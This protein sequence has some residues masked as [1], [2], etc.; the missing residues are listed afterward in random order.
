MREFAGDFGN[1]LSHFF[2]LWLREGGD[3]L[4][5]GRDSNRPNVSA[6]AQ[7]YLDRLD[8]D[9]EDLFH[10]VIATLHDSAYRSANAGA[11]HLEWLRIPLPD[12]PDGAAAGAA[13]EL[14]ASAARGRELAALLDSDTPV[15]GVTAGTL[16]PALAAIAVPM[17]TDG[18]NMATDDFAISAGWGHFGPGKAVMP[19]QGKIVKRDYTDDERT[20]LTDP[21]TDF[22][23]VWGDTTFDVY[24]NERAYLRNVP[25][26]VWELPTRWLPSSQEVLSYRE[27][28]I[29]GRPLKSD[30]V[31]HFTDTARRI[32]AI[33]MLTHS[34]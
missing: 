28:K 30:E 8:L 16:R 2:P 29:L 19:G 11:L 21:T 20:A 24:L 33:L 10:H 5:D 6:N 12:W 9:V 31:Q 4:T 1:G 25:A 22:E 3:L 7:R 17:T 26:A 13:E 23:Q 27:S 15:A 34:S 14:V 18:G 32:A